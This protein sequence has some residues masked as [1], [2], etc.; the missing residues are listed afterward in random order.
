M[1]A[2][3]AEIQDV[4]TAMRL[5]EVLPSRAG[6]VDAGWTKRDYPLTHAHG[7]HAGQLGA[8]LAL[9]ESRLTGA[10]AVLA[11]RVVQARSTQC[12]INVPRAGRRDAWQATF[13]EAMHTATASLSRS[14]WAVVVEGEAGPDEARP[15][16]VDPDDVSTFS[17]WQLD[18]TA[19]ARLRVTF[20]APFHPASIDLF[21]A[22]VLRALA[23]LSTP[24][25]MLLASIGVI[26]PIERYC[27]LHRWN[28]TAVE[29]RAGDTVHGLFTAFAQ[30]HLTHTAVEWQSGA[31]SYGELEL[32]SNHVAAALMAAGVSTGSPVALLLDRSADAIVAMLGILK[33]G[34]AY[35][36]LDASYP[37]ERLAF[38]IGDARAALVIAHDDTPAVPGIAVPMVSLQQ[39]EAD[40]LA[41]IPPAL[42]G[43]A[44]AYVMYTSGSTGTPKGAEITHRAIIRLV[45]DVD[46]VD[47]R[48]RPRVLHAAPLGFDASTLEIWGALLNGGT[49][50]IHDERIPS[51]GGLA[52]TIADHDV[53]IAWLS[54]ALFNAIV[55]DDVSKLRGL[56]Q[57]L[58]GGEALSV[59]HVRKAYAAL[60]EVRIINGY[61]PTECTTFSAAYRIPRKLD[62][63]LPSIPIGRPIADTTLHVL[64]ARGEHVP[65]GVIGELYIG[66]AGLARGYLGRPQLTRERFVV[67]PF[68]CPR[69]DT[70]GARLYRT[71]DLVRWLP[72]GV[73][74]FIGRADGQ[75]K[76]RGYRIELGEVEA[77]LQRL[78]GVRA[79][80]VLARQDRPDQK[81]L[82]AYYVAAD[83]RVTA[84]HLREQLAQS[85]PEFMVPGIYLRLA[86]LPITPNGKLDRRALPAP[87]HRR[88]EL[89]D[90]YVPAEG[91]LERRLC[92]L[93]ADVLG[94]GQVGRHDHFFDLGGDSLL[95]VKAVARIH[96]ELSALPTIPMFYGEPTPAA[97]A[98]SIEGRAERRTARIARGKGGDQA[99]AIAIVAMAGRFPG[100]G[101]VETF[102]R[103]LCE[104]RETITF[105]SADA[106]D[107]AIP[108]EERNHPDYVAARG[109]ID[110]VEEFDAGFFGM[111]PREAELTDPQQ[112]IFLELCWECMERGGYVPD[113]Q[114]VPV[115]VFG[116]MHNATYYQRHLNA[117]PDLIDKLGAFQVMLANEKDYLATHVAHKLNLTGPAISMNTGCSTSLVAICQAVAALRAGQCGMA[118]AGG[119]SVSCPPRSGYLSQE[120]SMLSPDG[121][122]RTFDAEARGTVFSDGAAVVLLKRLSDAQRDNDAIVAV[123]RGVAINND[124]GIKASFT[125]PSSAG[126]A[127]VVAMALDDAG[128]SARSI[129]YVETHGTAT[130]LGDPI[131][132]EGLTLA[133]REHTDDC[134]FCAV[135]SVKSNV[136]HLVMAAGVAGVIKT[137]LALREHTLP[138]SLYLRKTNPKIDFAHSPFVV[139]D[140]L[141]EWSPDEDP[142]R[143]GVSSFGVGGT[144][145]HV[146]LEE[147]PQRT[148][149]DVATGA[150]LLLLSARSA[151]ALG[152]AAGRLGEYLAAQPNSQLGDVAYTLATGRKAF[153][154]RTYVVASNLEEATTRLA[155][156]DPAAMRT[157]SNPAPGM[158][159][160]FPGQ[161]SQYAGMGRELHATEPVFRAALDAC[162]EALA[163]ELGF[164][165]RDRLFADDA[166]AYAEA[167]GET[168]LTQPAT[169]AVEYAM[170]RLW[171]SL[172]IRPVA[173]IGHSV[174]E[175]VAAVMAGV[176]SLT[177]GARLVA[178]RAHLMQALPAGSMLSVRLD[179]KQLAERLPS[180]LQIAAENA[181]NACVVSGETA[182]V[183][184]FRTELESAGIASRLLHTS[185]AF[186]SAMMEPVLAPFRDEVAG[187]PLAAPSIP[188]VSTVTGALLSDGEATSIDYWTRQLR[189]TVRFSTALLSVLEGTQH[190]FLEVGP[191]IALAT[192]ARQHPQSRGR[193]VL[194]SL[195][196]TPENERAAWLDAAGRLWSLGTPLDVTALDHRQ[197]KLHVRLP[198][199]P[200]ERKRY[201]IDAQTAVTST[202]P[203][204]LATPAAPDITTTFVTPSAPVADSPLEAALPGAGRFRHR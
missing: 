156:I 105:F 197:R 84:R 181:P 198:T 8:A 143:A 63:H 150:Q 180:T 164:D 126:Q 22:C 26:D 4:E 192:L 46:Y 68:N 163:N 27:L 121:H 6:A 7:L 146:I 137:A 125:A 81:R 74:E 154:Q 94:L 58:I 17:R 19:P 33:A 123:I 25:D 9:A 73:I 177:D 131:E 189:G 176:M 99:E 92:E 173:M 191:R 167:L 108:A 196:D 18:T 115:G 169:F 39:L 183:G 182:I 120:G 111:S 148:P 31:L 3:M 142:L 30:R 20:R 155:A 136:G 66:G 51:G 116:G 145:A 122:T 101:D 87:D 55:D 135:G 61:G 162:A 48:E 178:R 5:F 102:W 65:V 187:I 29:R 158:V 134:G 13:L 157:A 153:A 130:P 109:V 70:S 128:V 127:A 1:N 107:P 34:A 49:C 56:R 54:A 185:H 129:S 204:A 202:A 67:P 160:L 10:D 50:V 16:E 37:A 89:A 80:A 140:C 103:H 40:A 200:F 95:A 152:H 78:P 151:T 57:L 62:A 139:N 118:L 171:M 53:R 100:A 15:D 174:G 175:F 170:A 69:F 14:A 72:G 203:A 21:A 149:S 147:P 85:L 11:T 144:N 124:G 43:M 117:R 86:A 45:R 172:G 52:R 44:L 186:H 161:G 184:A 190:A 90:A 138:P 141:R 106:L 193:N 38:A 79:S 133:F 114:T 32:R 41:A 188:I 159:F 71:G 47:L 23:A 24:K 2:S 179:A 119:S 194:S 75:V 166:D 77:A 110:G 93:F 165:L 195:A 104:G 35:L 12:L 64:N 59:A 112:R 97:L 168:S 60:P 113:A 42:N 132:I 76:I 91:P 88:P 28:D 201:W 83:D 82:V 199:Y 98:A 96:A 36:P